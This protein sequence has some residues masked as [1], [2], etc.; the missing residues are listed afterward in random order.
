MANDQRIPNETRDSISWTISLS[1]A[2]VV[3]LCLVMLFG[4]YAD[5]VILRS[6]LPKAPQT[7]PLTVVILLTISFSIFLLRIFETKGNRLHRIFGFL[8]L[9][10]AFYIIIWTIFQYIYN[11]PTGIELI[12]FK[13]AVLEQ[14]DTYPGRPSPHTI[15]ANLCL[16][17]GIMIAFADPRNYR[18]INTF[19]YM[20]LII[21]WIALFGYISFFS[22]FY[23][24][25]DVPETGM[26]PL[27]AI[28]TATL[29]FVLA[30]T[31]PD[32]GILKLFRTPSLGGLLVRVLFPLAI[33]T[34]LIM[35][36]LFAYISESFIISNFKTIELSWGLA[37][38]FMGTLVLLGGNIV[39]KIDITR[40]NLITEINNTEKKLRTVFEST[41]DAMIIVNDQGEIIMANHQ[42]ETLFGH[43]EEFLLD[44]PV[45]LLMPDRYKDLHLNYRNKYITQPERLEMGVG[46]FGKH[47]DGH[48][49]NVEIS[50]SP[51][52]F[53]DEKVICAVIRDV[54]VR[55]NKEQEIINLNKELEA[56]TYSV[57][58]DLQAPLRSIHSYSKILEEEHKKEL[59]KQGKKY[60]NVIIKNVSL[61]NA[62]IRDLLSFSRLGT[63]EVNKLPVDLNSLVEN[64]L[65]NLIKDKKTPL[66]NV[67]FSTQALPTVLGDTMLLRQVIMNLLSN[68]I[69]YSRFRD[70]PEIE[71]GLTRI[72]S[73]EVI[74]IRDNG[75]G[76]DMKYAD[77]IFNVFERLHKDE[78]YEGTGIGLALVKKIIERHGGKVWAESELNKGSTFFFS[79]PPAPK[80]VQ[81]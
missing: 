49:F 43:S 25:T 2:L 12:L 21:P 81:L 17:I 10:L 72:N 33:L 48:E 78:E 70:K 26:S 41:P 31:D 11:L 34:P 61:M 35:S 52:F 15:I 22:P 16:C 18:A 59:G 53:K 3:F 65:K 40:Q 6:L 30:F 69:K 38:V 73:D 45:E 44:Q 47:K 76:F 32:R 74:Y 20:G 58:H 8:V 42:T 39:H 57:S 5:I 28:C 63:K 36:W 55:K 13:K 68:A 71:I 19:A 27:T 7:T 9:T 54:T 51:I 60:L 62:L 67:R 29:C 4:W 80:E 56:F 66:D 37:S 64:V 79:I 77:K 23:S 14:S 50:L 46:L 1:L 24:P 75:T